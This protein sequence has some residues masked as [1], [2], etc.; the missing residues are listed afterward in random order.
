VVF[1][2]STKAYLNIMNNN[3]SFVKEF[4][5]PA[6]YE[7]IV[8]GTVSPGIYA[9]NQGITARSEIVDEGKVR[10]ILTGQ[11]PDIAGLGKLLNLIYEQQLTI[12]SVRKLSA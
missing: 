3:D 4:D 5:Q 7:I 6:G 8:S 2:I 1:A 12:I 10:T 9:G 11:F